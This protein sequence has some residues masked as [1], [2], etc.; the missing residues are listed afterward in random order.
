MQRTRVSGVQLKPLAGEDLRVDPETV[1]RKLKAELNRRLK[2]RLLN[3]PAFSDRARKSLAK[4]IQ[5]KIFPNSL[6][7]TT[8]HPGFMPLLNGRRKVQMKWLVK[9]RVPIPI[10]LDSGE[11]IFRWAT[12][13]SMANGSW[14][15]P[16]RKRVD[17]VTKAKQEARK[18]IRERMA[19]AAVAQLRSAIRGR[20]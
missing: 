15:H 3:T 9:A 7:I 13:Q 5:I 6:L 8:N 1:L 20:F 11:I 19:A 16:G 12:P 10:T 14:W 17:F 2:A 4:S 18:I